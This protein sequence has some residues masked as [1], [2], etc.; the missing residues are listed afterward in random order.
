MAGK[1]KQSLVLCLRF[2][3][4]GDVAIASVVV[5]ACARDN[6]GAQF[7]FAGP[8]LLSPLFEGPANLSYVPVAKNQPLKI[9][10]RT[11]K[12]VHPT[13]VA[14]LHSVM[15]SFFLRTVFFLQGVPVAFLHKGRGARR[16]LLARPATSE[17]LTP[18][19]LRYVQTLEK[20]GFSTPSLQESQTVLLKPGPW[21]K[22]GIAPFAQ[23]RGKQWPLERM[24]EIAGRLALQ[25]TLVY[26]FG[27]GPEEV[28]QLQVWTGDHSNIR[29]APGVGEPVC[30]HRQLQSISELDVMVSMDS[31][32]MHFASA[33]GIPVLS[34]WGATHP[35]AG[36]YG[37]RQ[38]PEGA[39]QLPLDCR[40]CSVYGAG[41][42]RKGTYECLENLTVE[43]VM[44]Y[45][46]E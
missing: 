1:N 25:G 24:R 5:K 26:L 11:L 41:T 46:R 13:H 14:D 23:H 18:M 6:P 15:R 34:V 27:G 17:P 19:Y 7:I 33:L 39:I 38:D 37:Y 21:E 4:L 28:A 45:V 12:K 10:L 43:H 9:I 44:S 29:L 2:S 42:C 40:P 16:R 32:N 31:A 35:K 20:L 8:H 30:F 22:A 36:F 3:A